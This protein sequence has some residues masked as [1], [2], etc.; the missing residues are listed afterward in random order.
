M[1]PTTERTSSDLATAAR[2][3][4]ALHRAGDPLVLVNVWDVAGAT[5]VQQAGAR[6]VATSSAAIAASLGQPDDDSGDVDAIFAVLTRIAAASAV[7]VTADLEAGYGLAAPELVERMLTAG[8]VGCN[9]EDSDHT[10]PGTQVDAGAH[11]DR[12]AAVRAAARDAGVDLVINARVDSILRAGDR[13]VEEVLPDVI[14]RSRRYLDAGASCVYPIRLTDPGLV[15]R[16]VDEVGGP[17]NANLAGGGR[18]PGSAG[19]EPG[20]TVADQAAAGAARISLGARPFFVAMGA[21]DEVAA[22]VL[23]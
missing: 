16:V 9:L 18:A 13:G 23:G 11:A 21:F 19:A 8:I 10:T 2:E 6:A 15:R 3:L 12:L 17:V 7:P 4:L 22:A 1:A 20:S 5:R 14:A